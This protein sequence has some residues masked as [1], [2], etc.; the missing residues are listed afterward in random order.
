MPN[1]SDHENALYQTALPQGG[2]FTAKQAKAAGYSYRLQLYHAQRGHWF[3][4]ERGIYRLRN[5][6]QSEREDLIRWSLWS[7][8]RKGLPQ[9]TFSH[10]TALAF[11]ELGDFNPGR[12]H[13]TVPVSFKKPVEGGCILHRADLPLTDIE[14]HGGFRITTPL[15]ALVDVAETG[16]ERGLLMEAI[17]DALDRGLVDR[18][19]LRSRLS[20]GAHLELLGTNRPDPP[21]PSAVAGDH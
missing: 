1:P 18:T 10:E 11:H 20:A 3:K 17:Q 9:V 5:F 8:N 19:Q 15:R 21:G 7:V 4:I 6:P 14:D 13:I 12:L 2:Y 16:A